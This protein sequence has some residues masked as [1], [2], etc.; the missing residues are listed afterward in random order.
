VEIFQPTKQRGNIPFPLLGRA[1]GVA[2][3]FGA[4]TEDPQGAEDSVGQHLQ[5]IAPF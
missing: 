3:L 1:K 2:D 5:M 4:A